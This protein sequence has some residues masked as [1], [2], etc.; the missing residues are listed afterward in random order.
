MDKIKS[1]INYNLYGN[2]TS[3]LENFSFDNND[4]KKLAEEFD[5]LCESTKIVME[6]PLSKFFGK[7]ENF[8]NNRLVKSADNQLAKAV[9]KDQGKLNAAMGVM[10]SALARRINRLGELGKQLIVKTKNADEVTANKIQSAVDSRIKDTQEFLSRVM[11]AKNNLLADATTDPKKADEFIKQAEKAEQKAEF[12]S[13]KADAAEQQASSTTTGDS[14]APEAENTDPIVD[15]I[16]NADGNIKSQANKEIQNILRTKGREYL[17]NILK[18][19]GIG[20]NKGV[21]GEAVEIQ[22]RTARGIINPKSIAQLLSSN[23]SDKSLLKA[24]NKLS[25]GK[26]NQIAH[27]LEKSV[28]R[29]F[30]NTEVGQSLSNTTTPNDNVG[31]GTGDQLNTPDEGGEEETNNSIDAQEVSKR[32][33]EGVASIIA[34]VTGKNNPGANGATANKIIRLVVNDYNE[35]GS[36]TQAINNFATSEYGAKFGNDAKQLAIQAIDGFVDLNKES[37]ERPIV[38]EIRRRLRKNI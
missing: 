21:L 1:L 28:M 30:V 38:E 11:A 2:S 26:Q 22:E 33:L 34:K 18:K 32:N 6:G 7:I 3:L 12:Q 5:S 14:V 24:F 4:F 25:R 16:K 20:E 8:K 15:Q 35:T 10:A 17:V 29:D 19:A 23:A 13:Q 36:A 31:S 27:Q 9:A 37:V